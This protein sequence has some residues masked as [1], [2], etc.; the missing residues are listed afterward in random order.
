VYRVPF[1][2]EDLAKY[3]FSKDAVEYLRSLKFSVDDLRGPVGEEI[4]NRALERI[5]QAVERRTIAPVLHADYDVELLSFPAAILLL[6][7]IGDRLLSSRYAVAEAKRAFFFLSAEPLEKLVYLATRTFEWK[8]ELAEERVGS[9]HYQLRVHFADYLSS[10][11]EFSP[12]WKLVNRAREGGMVLVTK[13]EFARLL[14][15][16]VK[17]YV[18]MRLAEREPLEEVPEHVRPWLEEVERVWGKIK[19]KVE[20]IR[21][22]PV[23]EEAYPPC[24]RAILA[25]L[26]AGKNLPHAARF[27]LATFLLNVGKSVDEVME[28]FR[29]APDFKESIARYQ[30]EHLAGLRGSRKKYS[31]FKCENMRSL[32]LCRS[33]GSC[34]RVKH[35]LQY[36]YVSAR[37]LRRES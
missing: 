5:L 18:L 17:D 25:D 29:M 9:R 16:A 22:G 28:L 21:A 6:R 35:P 1:G 15:E 33:D 27:A 32:G 37:K 20:A 13:H 8:V 11:P 34:G 24:M 3:P 31:P 30:V 23:V 2:Q 36:Y 14:E 7:A 12:P 26:K 4:M 19:T 10:V